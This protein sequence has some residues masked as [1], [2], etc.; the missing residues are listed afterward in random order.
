MLER[1]LDEEKL[2]DF[3][4]GFG[5]WSGEEADRVREARREAKE[6]R[7]QRLRERSEDA[8]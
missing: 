4:D 8:A 3:Y 7:T 6:K 2:G 1:I 5:R